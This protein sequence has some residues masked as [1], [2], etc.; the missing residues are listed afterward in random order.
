MEELAVK[1]NICDR[2]YPMKV[3][4][5][6]EKYVRTAGNLITKRI[7]DY[8]DKFGI[9]DKQD[10]LTMV[11]LD[12]CIDML[13]QKDKAIQTTHVALEQINVLGEQVERVLT[14]AR[15]PATIIS[16]PSRPATT[17]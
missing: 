13:K 17:K 1:I 2:V 6:D 3:H 15:Q 9:H 8:S 11:A 14:S 12:C 5:M 16:N 4:S 7:R 10:L